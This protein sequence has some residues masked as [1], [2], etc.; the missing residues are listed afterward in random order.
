MPILQLEPF[1]Y[2]EQLF[3]EPAEQGSDQEQWWVLHTRPRAEKSLARRLFARSVSFFL[4][5]YENTRRR[6]GRLLTSHLPLFPGYVFLRG[7]RQARLEALET[8]LIA[9]CIPVVDQLQ[10]QADLTRV[11]HLMASGLPMTPEQHLEPG[12]SVE[13][14]DGPLAGLH[15]KVIQRGKGLKFY[16][17]VNFLQQGASV[18]IDG[19]AIRPLEAE[20]KRLR[21]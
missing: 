15:G 7:D 3:E 13:I 12:D 6:R 16:V 9:R 11:H 1:L 10:L 17:Q 5:L 4:P 20:P 18:E 2:P 8:N 14:T 21:A 19:W